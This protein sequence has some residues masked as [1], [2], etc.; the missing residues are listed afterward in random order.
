MQVVS[1]FR[2]CLPQILAVNIK[3][4]L[5]L[6]YGLTMGMPTILIP[7]LNGNNKEEVIV[8]DRD[9]ISWLGKYVRSNSKKVKYDDVIMKLKVCNVTFDSVFV[10]KDIMY[11]ILEFTI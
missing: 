2:R 8:L 5:L 9:G 6:V 11:Y 4:T 3:N 1:P 7:N 10:K